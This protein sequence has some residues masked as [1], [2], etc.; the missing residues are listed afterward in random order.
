MTDYWILWNIFGQVSELQNA[1]NKWFQ[2]NNPCDWRFVTCSHYIHNI[3][4]DTYYKVTQL[5]DFKNIGNEYEYI[6]TSIWPSNLEKLTIDRQ[7]FSDTNF[8]LETLPSSI[9]SIDINDRHDLFETDTFPNFLTHTQLKYIDINN[10]DIKNKKSLTS[11]VFP[12][13]L[14]SVIFGTLELTGNLK[15]STLM[16]NSSNLTYFDAYSGFYHENYFDSVDFNGINNDTR[17][18]LH[19]DIPCDE[20]GYSEW[21]YSNMIDAYNSNY[22]S[23]DVEIDITQIFCT[24]RRSNECVGMDECFDTCICFD[25]PSDWY[26]AL[27]DFYRYV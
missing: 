12:S 20:D 15:F 18:L 24:K 5:G 1:T 4:N 8:Q 27:N 13:S 19:E 17:V 21:L 10:L 25:I 16:T 22:N 3:T 26:P 7:L 14:Q 11:T 2:T 9:E 23:S 6:N